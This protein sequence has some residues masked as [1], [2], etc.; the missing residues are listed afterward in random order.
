MCWKASAS[1]DTLCQVRWRCGIAPQ[2]EQHVTR[3][4]CTLLGLGLGLCLIVEPQRQT[5][6]MASNISNP[7]GSGAG[8]SSLR[9]CRRYTIPSEARKKTT[10]TAVGND[11]G[12][13][14]IARLSSSARVFGKSCSLVKLHIGA[15]FVITSTS[16]SFMAA[17]CNFAVCDGP[18]GRCE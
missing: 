17:P 10:M 9:L 5:A 8:Y 13:A 6:H 14:D 16:D 12:G 3:L 7:Q 4:T 2:L 15:A 11:Q 1:I 18:C